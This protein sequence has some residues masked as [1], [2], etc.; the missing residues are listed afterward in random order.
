MKLCCGIISKELPKRWSCDLIM[1]PVQYV[2]PGNYSVV[3]ST[4]LI[5]STKA[6]ARLKLSGKDN[7]NKGG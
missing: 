3:V 5:G 2:L 6:V 1:L 7:I 4:R